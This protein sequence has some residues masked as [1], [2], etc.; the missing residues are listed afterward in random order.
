MQIKGLLTFV[1]ISCFVLHA[2]VAPSRPDDLAPASSI[3]CQTVPIPAMVT[4]ASARME[5]AERYFH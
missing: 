4:R 2:Q 1:F 3:D 5:K